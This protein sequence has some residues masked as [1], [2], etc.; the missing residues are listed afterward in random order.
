VSSARLQAFIEAPLPAV[1]DLIADVDRH[2]EWWPRV[3]EV[4]CEGLE[5]GCTYREVVKSPFG[6]EDDMEMRIDRLAENE[7]LRIRCINTGT[8]C[9]IAL[10]EAQSGT[11]VDGEAGMEPATLQTRVFD[12]LAGKRYFRTWMRQTLDA[13]DRVACSGPDAKK[14]PA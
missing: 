2:P 8:Y 3:I 5:E 14:K 10:T 6:S 11:F 12:A 7:E 13:L 4:H 9:K 1:W